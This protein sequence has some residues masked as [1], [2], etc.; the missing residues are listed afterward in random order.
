MS[1]AYTMSPADIELS[2]FNMI[3]QQVRPWDVL[4]PA[5][6]ELLQQVRREDFT[7]PALR[8]LAFVDT[9]VPLLTPHEEALRLGQCMLAPRVEARSVQDLRLAPTDRVLEIGT[10]SGFSAALM[11]HL[12]EHVLT[13]EIHAGLAETARANLR[14]AGIS[15][16]EVR[17][18]DG[19]QGAAAHGP[20]DA[21]LLSGSVA[22]VPQA[23]LAQLKPG[24]RLFAIA[25]SEPIMRAQ[26]IT[27]AGDG[28]YETA[29]PWDAIVPRL[30]NFPEPSAFQF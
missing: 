6:L 22:A 27:H 24:G 29:T 16:V 18:A 26:V 1:H 10:G 21:I 4:D 19:A 23:L 3:E 12:A 20:F 5:V 17:H 28:R 9:E 14:A 7:P 13:L 8:A 25:G 15:N 30:L 11:A 2:R